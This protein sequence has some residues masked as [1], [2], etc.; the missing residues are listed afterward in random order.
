LGFQQFWRWR[1]LGWLVR[2]AIAAGINPWLV[3]WGIVKEIGTIGDQGVAH[4]GRVIV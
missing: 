4:A 3:P 1:L 2:G